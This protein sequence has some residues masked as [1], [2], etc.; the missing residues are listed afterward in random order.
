VEQE[1]LTVTE[2]MRS[3]PVGCVVLT[4]TEYTRSSPV[5][6]VVQR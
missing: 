4:V 3:S 6:C 1:L 5:G 2:Y